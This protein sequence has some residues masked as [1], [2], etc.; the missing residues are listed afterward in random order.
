MN[1]D[2]RTK[3]SI[4]NISFS[5]ITTIMTILLS[6]IVRFFFV[7]NF[8]I[9]YLGLN[10]LFTNVISLLSITESG[11]GVAI[12]Y[13]MYKPMAN[14]DV[15][16]IRQLIQYFKKMYLFVCLA[17]L[18]CGVLVIPLLPLIV[19]D[20][21]SLD[22][23]F[24]VIYSMFLVNT[25][26]SFFV[27]H[28]RSLFHCG[29]RADL[30]Q[31]ITFIVTVLGSSFQLICILLF[32]NYYLFV[33]SSIIQTLFSMIFVILITN[34]KY[35]EYLVKPQENLDN[36]TRKSIKKNVYALLSHKVGGA[37]LSGT[38]SILISAFVGLVIL[39]KYSNYLLI[40]SALSKLLSI[41]VN[42][43]QGSIGNVVATKN[44]D[45]SYNIFKRLNFMYLW[46][47]SF[48]S[49]GLAV[50]SNPFIE[51]VFG[52]EY[53]FDMY[54]VVLIAI[55]F[56]FQ[57]IRSLLYA[58]KD[59]CGLFWQNRYMP[60]AEAGINLVVSVVLG[61]FIGLAGIILGTIVS[62]L[63]MPFWVEP[64]VLYKHYFNR[65]LWQHFKIILLNLLITCAVGILC[66]FLIQYIV[67]KSIWG[68][69]LKFV[70]CILLSNGMIALLYSPTNEFK[71]T[72]KK[73]KSFLSKLF[74]KSK[75]NSDQVK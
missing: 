48:C 74:R 45:E 22:V 54:I 5:L 8:V 46:L 15:N 51:C 64:K 58:F 49:I 41:I 4:R 61:K 2:S 43:V 62:N 52:Q 42:S 33:S 32:K 68:V 20:Y 72:M 16:K 53:V 73:V 6:A 47:V 19:K 50:L 27:A 63:L 7:R 66:Y 39:G 12:A 57:Y 55:Q 21:A 9:E 17:V 59:C 67:I 31:K 75:N 23:N 65:N 18:V 1:T 40:V 25:L 34:K 24:Y 44:I 14:G 10:G 60:I 28:R 26:L 36:E 35:K 71:L 13:A 29:Q 30:E 11:F 3:N 56:Y 69:I 37:V 70:I 38:D